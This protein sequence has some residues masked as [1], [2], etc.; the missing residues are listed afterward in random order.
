M[1]WEAQVLC[2]REMRNA[3]NVLTQKIVKER[4]KLE[5]LGVDVSII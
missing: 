4:D 1:R 3:Y 5:D 2:M